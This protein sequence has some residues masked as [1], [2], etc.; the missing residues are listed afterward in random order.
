MIHICLNR[1]KWTYRRRKTEII[2]DKSKKLKCHYFLTKIAFKTFHR[3]EMPLSKSQND[4]KRN[5]IMC[6]SSKLHWIKNTKSKYLTNVFVNPFC[7]WWLPKFIWYSRN[8]I[9]NKI[10]PE[11]QRQTLLSVFYLPKDIMDISYWMHHL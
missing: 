4:K 9:L 6:L 3:F 8:T 11:W 1:M 5:E 10:N 2:C 7:V